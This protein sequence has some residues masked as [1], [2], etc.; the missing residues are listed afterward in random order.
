MKKR[1]RNSYFCYMEHHIPQM[2]DHLASNFNHLLTQC[3]E[4]PLFHRLGQYH[5]SQRAAEV[6]GQCEQLQANLIIHEII[7]GQPGHFN[8]YLPSLIHCSAVPRLEIDDIARFPPKVRH[9]IVDSWKKLSRML[10]DLGNDF[11]RLVPTG[12][13]VLK[14]MI[15]NDWFLRW[16]TYRPS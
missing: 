9:D 7:T 2:T 4:Q 13:P 5:M 16:S 12:C 3:S 10:L 6:V 8:A 15:T 11:A 14:T 1:S